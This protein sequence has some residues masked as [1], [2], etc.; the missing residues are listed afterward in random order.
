M[1]RTPT[2]IDDRREESITNDALMEY[3]K[4]ASTWLQSEGS[5]PVAESFF[6][7]HRGEG[8][9]IENSLYRDDLSTLDL[10]P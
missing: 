1:V 5:S 6:L 7:L 3:V 10:V 4:Q 8:A 9:R 2:N